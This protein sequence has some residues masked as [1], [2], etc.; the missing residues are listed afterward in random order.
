MTIPASEIVDVIPGTL[1]PGG[2]S[3]DITGLL[4]DNSTRV[5]VGQV[6]DFPNAASVGSYFGLSSKQ[7]KFAGVYFEGYDGATAIPA[8]LLVSQYPAAAV[9]AYLRGGVI[10]A[11]PL[12][13]LQGL[14]GTLSV[15]IDG[16]LKTA[17]INLAAS[18][19]FSNA[20][21]IIAQGLGIEGV[22]AAT[23]TAS[24]GGTF[25][26]TSSGTTLSVSAV[27]TGSL[28][29]TDAVSGTDGTNSLPGGATIVKQLTGTPG[30][31]GT[32]QLSAAATPGNLTSCTVT[33]LSTVLNVTVVATGA[34]GVADV[35]I[36]ASVPA[37]T[38]VGSQVSGVTGGAGTYSLSGTG[39]TIASEAMTAFTPAVVYDAVA[40]AFT[41]LSGTVGPASTIT[42]GSGALGASLLLEQANGAVLSQGA[43]AATPGPFMSALVAVNNDWVT[44]TT[45]FDPDGGS[46]NTQKQAFAAW[47]NSYTDRYA[48]VAWDTDINPTESLPTTTSLGYI[49]QNNND[50]GSFLVYEPTDLNHAAF[51]MGTAAAI[52]F[53]QTAGRITF[54]FRFQDGLAAGVTS[55]TAANN[56][57]G[58]GYNFVGAYASANEGFTWLQNGQC[59]G[60]FKWFDSYINQVW[61]NT[62]F[63]NDL[64][65]FLGSVNSVP[66]N[67]AGNAM[68]ESALQA[69]IDAGLNFG[70][71]GPGAI[72]ASQANQVNTTAGNSQA[73]STLQTQG[74]YLQVSPS[75]PNT[76]AARASPPCTFWY[77]DNGSVQKINLSSVA[78]Q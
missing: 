74:W 67:A 54:A 51:V 76:R 20:A 63:Q 64:L 6:L 11:M 16:T 7:Y 45:D 43:A 40:G 14:S 36:G 32:Y 1:P 42:Y 15:T 22:Q 46:G 55:D 10:S 65:T 19:S 27:L 53:D 52:N 41:V 25:T 28:Q 8:A 12:A 17:S 35:I 48:Y 2:D 59:T 57:L 13:T 4:L 9:S 38:Y 73:A 77:L 21:E 66:Y 78:V 34:V 24:I 56:L 29:A 61:L 37:G 60:P 26:A 72:T 23:L 18:T 68:I 30:G 47:K 39:H 69:R 50:S 70:A 3:L 71:Y 58:N 62:G 33:S 31:V 44:Y 75:S 5:P 49:L